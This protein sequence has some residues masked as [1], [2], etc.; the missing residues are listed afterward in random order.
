MA[1]APS[2]SRSRP[3]VAPSLQTQYSP[4]TIQCQDQNEPIFCYDLATMAKPQRVG[5]EGMWRVYKRLRDFG[6]VVHVMPCYAPYDLLVDGQVR[7]E[8]KTSPGGRATY[9]RRLT[10]RFNIH[11]HRNLTES[12]TDC[13]VLRLE[14]LPEASYAIHLLLRAPIGKKT[15][16]VSLRSLLAGHW[17]QQAQD[18]EH[19]KR[20]GKLPRRK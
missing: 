17:A 2:P 14:N 20:T 15:I 3:S 4:G 7:V 13:Y 12:N 10:W 9:K 1:S 16:G 18:F 19:F 5:Y 11:R 8:V 6:R